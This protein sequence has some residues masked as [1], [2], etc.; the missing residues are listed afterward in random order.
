MQAH[1]RLFRVL[2]AL[3]IFVGLSACGGGGG[4]T[5]ASTDA[6]LFGLTLS[7]GAVSPTFTSGTTGY[8]LTTTATS[9]TVSATVN[10]ANATITVN[11]SAVGSSAASTAIALALGNTV[12]T[13][14]VTAQDGS[15]SQ[16]YTVTLSRIGDSTAPNI[17]LNGQSQVTVL[18]NDSFTDAGASATDDVDGALTVNVTGSVNT[19]IVAIYTLT[20]TATDSSG[21]VATET[22]TVNVIDQVTVSNLNDTGITVGANYPTTN[23]LS[24]IGETVA[25]QDCSNGRDALAQASNLIK[26]GVGHA[27]FDFTKLDTSGNALPNTALFWACVK[28]NNTGLVWEVKTDDGGIQDKDNTYRWGGKTALLNAPF[29][30][31]FDDWNTLLDGVNNANLCGFNDWKVPSKHEYMSIIHYDREFPALDNSF[32]PNTNTIYWTAS[33][34]AGPGIE[35]A[36]RVIVNNG[37]INHIQRNLSGFVR[38]VRSNP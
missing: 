12:I 4:S 27:G 13:V 2:F 3:A 26:T 17:V 36:W 28:D 10:Q 22:R 15:T 20:Y 19:S 32:F 38:L 7:A 8:T 29:G 18:Q 23:N 11:G 25:Q 37:G 6:T 33:P 24:C 9:T 5:T 16:T 21:N 31:Q 14:V 30:T 35:S 34:Y 1:H